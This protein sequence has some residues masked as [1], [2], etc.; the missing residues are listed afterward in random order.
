MR[1]DSFEIKKALLTA[2]FAMNDFRV[3]IENEMIMHPSR[4]Y[5][6][7]RSTKHDQNVKNVARWMGLFAFFLL[8]G[9]EGGFIFV[10]GIP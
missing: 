1:L 9:G 6:V 2:H 3:M 5:L 7:D 10:S 8:T 4:A